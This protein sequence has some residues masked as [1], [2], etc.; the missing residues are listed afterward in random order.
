MQGIL[1][2]ALAVGLAALASSSASTDD[3]VRLT[4]DAALAAA[5][6]KAKVERARVALSE[7]EVKAVIAASGDAGATSRVAFR[8]TARDERGAVLGTAYFDGHVVRTKRETVMVVV[9]PDGKAREVVLLAFQE[10]QEY[11]PTA[12]WYGQFAGKALDP[13]LALGAGIDG[14]SGA[15]LTARATT[16]AVRRALALHAVLERAAVPPPKPEAPKPE[17]PKPSSGPPSPPP[18]KETARDGAGAP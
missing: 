1:R 7:A 2:K 11:V 6:P 14:C 8:Y 5:F 13:K 9:A 3:G 12:R 15:T 18:P 16:A 10:P 17:A 4:V